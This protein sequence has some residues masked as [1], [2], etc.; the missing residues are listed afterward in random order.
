MNPRYPVL[1]TVILLIALSCT[2]NVGRDQATFET[3]RQNGILANEGYN[4][5][6][7]YVNDWLK[8]ADPATGL[9]PQNLTD[10]RDVWTAHNSAADN[11]PFMVLTAYLL[12]KE[13]Y[14][15]R[16]LDMLNEERRL[17]SRLG[18]LPAVYSFTKQDFLNPEPDT[19]Q[20]I[21]RTSEYIK[22]GLIPLTEYTGI[23]PWSDRMFEM[24][25]DLSEYVKVAENVRGDFFGNSADAE[26]NGELLQTLSRVYWMTG[27]EKYL[28][29]AMAIA[30]H[31]LLE[32]PGMIL[33]NERLRLR[34]HGCEIIAGLS[35]IYATVHYAKPAK[36]PVYRN[37]MYEIL[38]R[39]LEVGRNQDGM[40]YNEVNMI[41]GE[42]VDSNI[43]DNWGY[44]YKA[45]YTIYLLDNRTDYRDAAIKPLKI[46]N[47]KY[48]NFNCENGSSD[49]F[50]DAIESGINLYNREPVPE[51]KDWLDSEMKIMWSM[52]DTKFENSGIIEGWHGDVKSFTCL[53]II[54][55]STSSRNGMSSMKTRIT[56]CRKM[57][58][59]P[60][61]MEKS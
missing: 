39:I 17:T 47:R 14:H 45:Y 40:F 59:N 35:E 22:D 61:A 11:Y 21:F 50:A 57:T 49:G 10:G 3:A 13:L 53:L 12:D 38:D 37:R 52:Q 51:L 58:L 15:G 34:D 55:G 33:R 32:K 6:M 4:R 44:I 9:I 18:T 41:T 43:V 1:Y 20:I 30:D 27:D 23:S 48:R 28:D 31:Y 36:K 25:D 54:P 16:M 29:R 2:R 5:C 26:I 56:R 24:L 7:L 46:V 8:Q 60:F 19:A 42:P